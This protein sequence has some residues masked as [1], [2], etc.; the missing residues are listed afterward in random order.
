MRSTNL[1][2]VAEAMALARVGRSTLFRA[3]ASGDLPYIAP[4]GGVRRARL[5]RREVLARWADL[6]E[7]DMTPAED[8]PR[9]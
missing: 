9:A 4:T 1:L 8:G 3:M 6:D 2:T 5:I 7:S